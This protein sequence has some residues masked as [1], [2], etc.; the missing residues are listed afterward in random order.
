MGI[1]NQPI[2][3]GI[4]GLAGVGKSQAVQI[5]S[6]W[7]EF[8]TIYFGGIVLDEIRNRGLEV[9][10]Q[11]EAVVR[12]GLRSEFGM[13]VM[14]QKSLPIILRAV[15][16][17]KN[18]LIDGLYSQSE[19]VLLRKNLGDRLK[20]ISIHSNKLVRVER[21]RHRPVRPLTVEEMD[22]RDE[23]EIALLE[24]ASPI[25]LADYHILNNIDMEAFAGELRSCLSKI[26]SLS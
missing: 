10:H 14:A 13:D 12:E 18:V 22:L 15:A 16:S 11:N 20:T 25:A 26:F 1:A 4:V 7:M 21:L 24:K 8:E 2:V 9:T 17:S 6:E 19:Y 3:L 5:I 23:K